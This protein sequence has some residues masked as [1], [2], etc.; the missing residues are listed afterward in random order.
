MGLDPFKGNIEDQARI[1]C[2]NHMKKQILDHLPEVQDND[3][4]HED[5]N[6]S[7]GDEEM[8]DVSNHDD[9]QAEKVEAE[10][11]ELPDEGQ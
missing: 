3:D 2:K 8:A 1:F 9:E 7:K 5:S 6:N 10:T 11:S 4:D